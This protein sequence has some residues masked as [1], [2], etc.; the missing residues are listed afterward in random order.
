MAGVAVAGVVGAWAV[1]EQGHLALPGFTETSAAAQTRPRA[2]LDQYGGSTFLRCTNKTGHFILSRINDRWWFCTPSGNVFIS[3]NVGDTAPPGKGTL[4]C[5]NQSAYD[6]LIRKYGDASYNWAVQTLK[7]MT[8]W[9]F[10]SIGQDSVGYVR[11]DWACKGCPWPGGRQPVPLPFIMEERPAQYATINRNNYASGP[12]KDLSNGM[13][14]NYR[15]YRATI[16]DVFDPVLGQWF[17]KDLRVDS[18]MADVRNNSPWLL[19]LYTDDSDYFWGSGS[20]PDFTAGGHSNANIG[21]MALIT[22]PTQTLDYQTQFGSRK[23]L[24]ADTKVYS[25]VDASNPSTACSISNPCSLRDYLWQ[26]Y[27]GSIA[28]LNKA[29]G[30]NY[31]TFDSSGTAVAGELIGTGDGSTKVFTHSLAH[32]PVSPDSIL[33]SVGETPQAGDCPWF[34]PINCGTSSAFRGTLVSPS[35]NFIAQSGSSINYSTGALTITFATALANR[36]VITVSYVYGGWM[37]G[38]IGLMDESGNNTGWVGTNPFCL[39]PNPGD[40]YF[41]CV[42]G[43]GPNNPV[44]NAN[45]RLGA[46]LDAWIAQMSAEYFSTMRTI[47]RRHTSVPYLGLDTIG[48]WAAPAS[49]W[50]LQGAGPYIDAAQVQLYYDLPSIAGALAAYSY[51]TQ[52]L[53]DVPLINFFT[54]DGQPD[55]A[56]SCHPNA[57][58]YEVSPNQLVRGQ[59]YLNSVR[60]FLTTAGYNKDY[61][62]VGFDWWAW[63]DFQNLNQGLVSIHDNAYDGKEAVSSTGT[64]PWGFS[65]GGESRDYGDCLSAVKQ[66]NALWYSLLRR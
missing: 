35:A 33:V 25:K 24:Y 60:L 27:H 13:N 32:G 50:F 36:A 62:W 56:E 55:S 39:E 6:I 4:D 54:L 26:K 41:A 3:M 8:A 1:A 52:Y 65:T 47:L 43:G 18:G 45:A 48:S 21:W 34:H 11:P 17:E 61:P 53:G 16:P 46:D 14:A 49:R 58:G 51:T 10:N 23:I 38:G 59:R 57:G 7:R 30:S 29:W 44:P 28:A 66:A 37:A 2:A 15:A 20:G 40:P 22:S 64:D 19:G 63:Q 5:N 31:T 9:G 42:G 12:L